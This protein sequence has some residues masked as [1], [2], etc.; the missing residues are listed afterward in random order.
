[1]ASRKQQPQPIVDDSAIKPGENP[2]GALAERYA[3]AI[4][5]AADVRK[6]DTQVVERLLRCDLF[7]DLS[8]EPLYRRRG[9]RSLSDEENLTSRQRLAGLITACLKRPAPTAEIDGVARDNLRLL[10]EIME[11]DEVDARVFLFT[12]VLQSSP[13][14]KELVESFGNTTVGAIASLVA[15]A[16][17]TAPPA[18]LRSLRQGRAVRSGL[19]ALSDDDTSD[20]PSRLRLKDGVLD[21]VLTPGLAR[22]TLIE[23]FLPSAPASSLTWGDFD[24]MAE[25][26]ATTRDLLGGALRTRL[27]GV[28]VLFYGVTG[29]GKTELAR[30]VAQALGVTLHC[31]SA[32]DSDGESLSAASRLTSLLLGHRLLDGTDA[33]MV[34]D[35]LEDLFA[36]DDDSFRWPLLARRGRSRGRA[37]GMSKAWFNQLLESNPVPTV[38]I[39]NE[40]GNVDPAFLRRFTFAVEFRDPSPKQR[41]RVLSRH[42]A[43][44]D[45]IAPNEVERLATRHAVP[46]AVFQRAL[47]AARVISPAGVAEPEAVSRVIAPIDRLLNG[48]HR[49]PTV[50]ID[51]DR[52]DLEALN[53]PVDLARLATRLEAWTPSDRPGV[54]LC[55]HGPPGTG[56]SEFVKYLARRL[57]RP[58]LYRRVSDL[59]SMWVGQTEK[60]IAAAFHQAEEEG[61]VL[62]FDE[63]DSFLRDRREAHRSWEVTQV[64]EFLQRLESFRGIVACTTNLMDDL[65]EA[66]L[67]RFVFKIPFGY[68]RPEQAAGLFDKVF[69][70]L[71]AAPLDEA[72]RAGLA[73]DLGRIGNLA[74]GDFAAVARRL[75]VFGTA[76]TVAEC[77]DELRA[78]VTVRR[79][80]TRGPLGFGA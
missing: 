79:R 35:E 63:A 36:G 31:A 78:E 44:S 46:A 77:L 19:L 56:K 37:H 23:R 54:T 28:N 61:S 43:P 32:E 16:T 18:A 76:A 24:A 22:S 64:N 45:R 41:A 73:A 60:A 51:A 71:L 40:V 38:W 39:S 58:V 8:P 67:R 4:L 17:G 5:R 26:A 66:S 6:L 75:G 42:L 30:L 10:G 69:S 2:F 59:Q 3:L 72:A 12:V 21:L 62:L 9:L 68:L 33:I 13:A 80:A 14:L 50:T 55:L 49:A 15:L 34:F 25:S 27:P 1:M 47:A 48:D 52:Y 7:S 74:P 70:P 20:A 29:S 57:G 53:T 65:D 11:F